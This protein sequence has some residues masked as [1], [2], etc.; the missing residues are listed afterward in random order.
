[1]GPGWLH[2]RVQKELTDAPKRSLSNVLERSQR[3]GRVPYDGRKEN[4]APSFKKGKK[5][6]WGTVAWSVFL[7]S[8]K[9]NRQIWD[10]RFCLEIEK[11][12]HPWDNQSVEQPKEVVWSLPIKVFKT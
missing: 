11:F 1:M 9:L 5:I 4:V 8:G 10:K 2:Q 12:F 3:S 6:I 7:V